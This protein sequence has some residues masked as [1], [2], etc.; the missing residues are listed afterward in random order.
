MLG[1]VVAFFATGV[2]WIPVS[3]SLNVRPTTSGASVLPST[4]P[5][6]ASSR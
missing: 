4:D 6:V 1:G 3:G 5:G 2:M